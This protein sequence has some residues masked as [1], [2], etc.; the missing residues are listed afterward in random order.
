MEKQRKLTSPKRVDQQTYLV[1]YACIV[2]ELL[3]LFLKIRYSFLAGGVAVCTL[4]PCREGSC[5]SFDGENWMKAETRVNTI[6][7]FVRCFV[8]RR[9]L[10]YGK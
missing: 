3:L 10:E 9:I 6:R 1:E 4:L 8:S 2:A 7:C 5:A